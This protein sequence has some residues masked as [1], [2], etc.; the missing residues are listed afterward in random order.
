MLHI[1]MSEPLPTEKMPESAPVAL[2]GRYELRAV[3]GEGGMGRV[4]RGFDRVLGRPVAIK[5]LTDLDSPMMI[6]RFEREAQTLSQLNHPNLAAVYDFGVEGTQPFTVMEFIDGKSL[7]RL[8]EES[9]GIEPEKAL[10]M[11]A[12]IGEGLAAAHDRG[13]VH[14]DIKPENILVCRKSDKDWVE[15][16]DF[17]LAISDVHVKT[18]DR[19]TVPG[20]VVGT[21]RYMS[22]EQM[23]GK[24]PTIATDIYAFGLV[25]AEM[26]AG[27]ENVKAGRL[28]STVPVKAAI[29]KYW[30]IIEK[31]CHEEPAERWP[32]VRAMVQAFQE[33]T[34][35]FDVSQ[36]RGR[37]TQVQTRSLQHVRRKKQIMQWVTVFGVLL[38]LA[39]ASSVFLLD[40]WHRREETHATIPVIAIEGVNVTWLSRDHLEVRLTGEVREAQPQR[41]TME[42]VVCDE[43]G[44]RIPG[45]DSPLEDKALGSLHYL[46]ITKVP[47][48]FHRTFPPLQVPSSHRKGYASVTIFDQKKML[49]AQQNSGFW[50]ERRP[51]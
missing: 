50:P 15:I 27:P 2:K 8:I 14:R 51:R 23:E 36:S 16:V 28:R 44:N 49:V 19:L 13:V 45:K 31:A 46:D 22:P 3:L 5:I 29:T 20:Y 37:S 18:D 41:M 39:M 43:N 11:I 25:C 9:G 38:S 6:Q 30:S 48:R 24:P 35:S 47:D 33:V 7:G 34:A 10:P 26:L 42:V 12:Q 4:H 40:H 1:S 21:Q 32:T 17:G